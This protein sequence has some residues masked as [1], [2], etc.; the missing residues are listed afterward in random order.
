MSGD[1][2]DRRAAELARRAS[3][4]RLE[5]PAPEPAR[6]TEKPPGGW[7]VL[8]AHIACD[9]SLSPEA[10]L[11][12]LVLSA[13]ADDRHDP[14][15]SIARLARM[16]GRSE[17]QILRILAELGPCPTGCA[18]GG[19]AHRGLV[20]RVHRYRRGEQVSSS[21]VL[22]FDRWGRG[23]VSPMTYRGDTDDT[24]RGDTG[25][26]QT[27]T[28][29]S[30]PEIQNPPSPPQ[31]GGMDHALASRGDQI[32]SI[33]RTEGVRLRD[34]RRILLAREASEAEG[35]TPTL[36]E[37]S[38]QLLEELRELYGYMPDGD[39]THDDRPERG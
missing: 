10:R 24:P 19:S 17:R 11:L 21:Y 4:H 20:E 6:P 39:T 18:C 7:A 28:M 32:R 16:V 36:P 1:S 2:L 8:P 22:R 31:A 26:I 29:G 23:G 15:P 25:G 13:H 5:L 38:A 3:V 12:L 33:A 37:P 34:A 27:K 9:P 35:P 30:R 14:F